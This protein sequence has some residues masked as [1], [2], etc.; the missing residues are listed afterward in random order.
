MKVE[1]THDHDF[2]TRPEAKRCVFSYTEGDWY[3]PKEVPSGDNT[4]RMHSSLS[5]KSPSQFERARN[6]KMTGTANDDLSTFLNQN[7]HS[8]RLKERAA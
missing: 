8:A 1:A 7:S 4:T 6:A 2:A 3:V 5:Y